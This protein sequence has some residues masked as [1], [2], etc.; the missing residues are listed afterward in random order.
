MLKIVLITVSIGLVSCAIQN[1]CNTDKC[2]LE[3]Y[4]H[5]TCDF[6]DSASFKKSCK[7]NRLLGFS[8]DLKQKWVDAHNKYRNKI[9]SG[10]SPGFNTAANMATMVSS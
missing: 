6:K 1:Y 7:N 3:S 4:K 10:G 2:N 9:A 8:D 5:I